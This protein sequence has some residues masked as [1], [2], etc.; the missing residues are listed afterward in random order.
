M[1]E[2]LKYWRVVAVAMLPLTL[3]LIPRDNF[4]AHQHTLCLFHNLFGKECWGCGM[5]RALL[6]LMYL[7][8]DTAW[9]YHRGVVVV[10]PLLVWQWGKW[11]VREVRR[12]KSS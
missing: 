8:F 7:D 11:I 5:S 6:S 4:F 9:D 3:Y 1:K 10:A 2:K 12:V